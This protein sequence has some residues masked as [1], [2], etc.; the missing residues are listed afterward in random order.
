MADLW[1]PVDPADERVLAGLEQMMNARARA[2]E[3]GQRPVGWKIGWNSPAVREQLGVSS[4]VIGFILD[5]GVRR[6][7]EGV[8]LTGAARPGAE[9]ELALFAGAGATVAAIGPG[10]EIVD[11]Y[12]DFG[13]VQAS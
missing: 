7:G 8:S 11:P 9:V 4:S 12:G 6:G 2:I 1:H 10:M 13:D 3:G 5:S